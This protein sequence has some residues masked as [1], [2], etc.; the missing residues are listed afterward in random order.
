MWSNW[1][2]TG[3]TGSAAQGGSTGEI[4]R[5]AVDNRSGEHAV[6]RLNVLAALAVIWKHDVGQSTVN[7]SD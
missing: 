2:K 3:N 1:G 6:M 7:L 4:F 5:F